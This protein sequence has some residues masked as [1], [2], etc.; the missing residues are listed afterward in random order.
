MN[1]ERFD[2]A[3]L[4]ER[5]AQ[6]GDDQWG[7]EDLMHGPADDTAGEEI[8]HGD[9]VQPALAGEDAGGIGSPDLIASLNAKMSDAVRRNRSMVTAVCGDG[10]ILGTLPSEDPF[11]AHETGDAVASS[12]AAEYP[13]YP[14][15]T[16]GLT[17]AHKLL[18]NA[19]AQAAVLQL[20]RSRVTTT[21][22]PIII[23]AA[24]H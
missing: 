15:A 11:C 20:A 23:T 1:D 21:L 14:W 8:K 12:R 9:E 6:S 19:L 7:I 13:S 5:H 22:D 3:T 16:V 18:A 2:R 4:S 24:R 10:A 17:T